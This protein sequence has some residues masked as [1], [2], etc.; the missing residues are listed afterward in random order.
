VETSTPYGLPLEFWHYFTPRDEAASQAL[1]AVSDE[2]VGAMLSSATTEAAEER[3]SELPKTRA[4]VETTL[5]SNHTALIDAV[6]EAVSTAAKL[7]GELHKHIDGCDPNK[8][9]PIDV[10]GKVQDGALKPAVEGLLDTGYG[11]STFVDAQMLS[12]AAF[13]TSEHTQME[14]PECSIEWDG[15]VGGLGALALRAVSPAFEEKDRAVA[16][17]FLKA[18]ATSSFAQRDV[19]RCRRIHLSFDEIPKALPLEYDEDG[20]VEG[21]DLAFTRDGNRYFLRTEHVTLE[22]FDDDDTFDAHGI[23]FAPDGEFKLPH[24]A[25]LVTGQALDGGWGTRDEIE[26]FITQ[27]ESRGPLAADP[28][29]VR[30]FAERADISVAEAA[31]FWLGL[32]NVE[33]WERNFLA[34]DVRTALGLKVAELEV[35]K[36][37]LRQITRDKRVRILD[38]AIPSDIESLWTSPGDGEGNALD[39]LTTRLGEVLG[40]RVKLPE[41]LLTALSKELAPDGDA[42]TLLTALVDPDASKPFNTDGRWTF[43]EDGDVVRPDDDDEDAA[44]FELHHLCGMAQLIPYLELKLPAGDP[45]RSN[46]ATLVERMR[47]RLSNDDLLLDLSVYIDEDDETKRAKLAESLFAQ[48][49]GTTT[50]DPKKGTKIRDDGAVIATLKS[51]KSWRPLTVAV[52]VGRVED[53]APIQQAF[54]IRQAVEGTVWGTDSLEALRWVRS[55]AFAGLVARLA[56]TPLPD[57]T[58]EA[59]P[60]HSAPDTVAAVVETYDVSEDAAVLYLQ[61]LTL[62]APTRKSVL[63]W[64]GWTAGRYKKACAELTDAKLVL[65]AKRSRAGREH[66]LPGAWESGPDSP[67]LPLETWKMPLYDLKRNATGGLTLPLQRILPRAPLHEMFEKAWARVESG[68]APAYEKVR[69]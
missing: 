46:V 11:H 4:L 59:N 60:L 42:R 16:L 51:G 55:S 69:R 31:L 58:F 67:T 27:A 19:G 3:D 56:N 26:A 8:E 64:N 62:A 54:A 66:F 25:T 7:S 9:A 37:T 41:E 15:L 14:L 28:D 43:D 5:G 35:A 10:R 45:L 53:D 22:Y 21:G 18:W 34:K 23:E 36:T 61:T 40:R 17:A 57:D 1:R 48:V 29:A 12:V 47:N 52:R 32:P 50:D 49:G 30:A 33:S 24:G 65:Q 39:R 63:L 68:D 6:L 13:F 38:A 20:D 2:A 44:V